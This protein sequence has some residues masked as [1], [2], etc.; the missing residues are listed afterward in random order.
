[1]LERTT[2]A[3]PYNAQA[4][5]VKQIIEDSITFDWDDPIVRVTRAGDFGISGRVTPQDGYSWSITFPAS[6]SQYDIPG[7]NFKN[8]LQS[9]IHE[10]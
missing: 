10:F 4:S 2:N 3:I 1:M 9:L 6:L 8:G 5:Q 7:N